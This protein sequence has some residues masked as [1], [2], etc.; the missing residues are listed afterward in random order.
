[1]GFRISEKDPLKRERI[2]R[3]F[4]YLVRYYSSVISEVEKNAFPFAIV[5]RTFEQK[6]YGDWTSIGSIC[7]E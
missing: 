4:G 2:G 7:F 3:R 5:L 1:M 6:I